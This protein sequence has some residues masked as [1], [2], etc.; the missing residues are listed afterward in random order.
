MRKVLPFFVT[1]ILS[2]AVSLLVLVFIIKPTQ[3]KTG[4]VQLGKVY[5]EFELS[6]TLNAQFKQITGAKKN[7][8]DSLEFQVKAIYT[9]VSANKS[10]TK[11]QEEFEIA[12]R[13]YLY[14]KEQFE[15]S[16]GAMEEEYNNKIW[17]QL[18]E[19]VSQY[20]KEKGYKYVFGADGSGTIMY[21][22]EAEDITLAVI[23]FVNEKYQGK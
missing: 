4:Y 11:L 7:Y 20:G 22:G 19:Y 16:V 3:N 6:K 15:Q 17:K 9:K 18:N 8:I 1:A 21:G 12:Q 2:V 14:Q 5:D 13:H 10:D 23:T